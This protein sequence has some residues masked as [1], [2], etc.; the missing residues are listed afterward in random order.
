MYRM[1]LAKGVSEDRII[2]MLTDDVKD[3]AGNTDRGKVR[4]QIG[5]AD[6][7]AGARIDYSGDQVTAG[8]FESVL[9]GYSKE[10]K[11]VLQTSVESDVLVYVAGEGK[12]GGVAFANSPPLSATAFGGIVSRMRELGRYRQMLVLAQVND[13]ADVCRFVTSPG[14]V[15]ITAASRGETAIPDHYN[16][17][18]HV[19]LTDRFTSAF[20]QAVSRSR[21]LS[22]A[23]I[24]RK[25]YLESGGSHIAL[26]NY[27]NFDVV[28]TPISDF[29]TP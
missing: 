6:L 5:G 25:V 19:W 26:V 15:G 3:D 8:N 29:T 24:Y 9:L 4:D 23:D 21:N 18:L 7:R 14:V 11:P 13:G 28:G 17:A 27:R 22:V 1:L 16:S 2:L 20:K 12:N 10:G